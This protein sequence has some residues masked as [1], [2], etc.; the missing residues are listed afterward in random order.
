MPAW[1]PY[2]G[3]AP[4]PADT[5]ARWNFGPELVLV[6]FAALV[7]IHL[8]RKQLRVGPALIAIGVFVFLFVSPF[9]ALG[10]ALFTVRI[11]HDVILAALL[12]PFLVATL[13]L[14]SRRIAG[15]FG[16]WTAIHAFTFWIWHAPPLYTAAL[17]SDWVFWAMQICAEACGSSAAWEYEARAKCQ[18]HT[19]R[20]ICLG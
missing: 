11:V 3:S 9:C 20:Q 18:P 1:I 19:V 6:I 2:C 5:W 7:G 10:S 12:A 17:S 8:Y 4:D 16:L 15:S 13:R 14:E